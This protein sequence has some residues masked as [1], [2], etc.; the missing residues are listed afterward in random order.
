[1]VRPENN[2]E[3]G[4]EPAGRPAPIPLQ[5]ALEP[6]AAVLRAVD[7]KLRLGQPRARRDLGRAT[8]C[9]APPS[10]PCPCPAP[11]RSRSAAW[12]ARRRSTTRAGAACCASSRRSCGGSRRAGRRGCPAGS[13]ACRRRPRASSSTTGSACA[14][15][16]APPGRR[17]CC[18]RAGGALVC[19]CMRRVSNGHG[20]GPANG[21]LISTTERNTSGRTSAHQAA[22]GEPKSCPTT[23][24]TER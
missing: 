8:A 5:A 15:D 19:G 11:S 17:G 14:A 9:A 16:P 7:G 23:A 2:F 13:C 24:A 20:G 1:M 6:G 4:L 3:F 12:P 21:A 18:G 22:T 10:P